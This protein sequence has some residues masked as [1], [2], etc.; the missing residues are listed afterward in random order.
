MSSRPPCHI[1]QLP[2]E[3]L[4]RILVA[5]ATDRFGCIDLHMG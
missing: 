4:S 2:D 5:A 3:L 1:N